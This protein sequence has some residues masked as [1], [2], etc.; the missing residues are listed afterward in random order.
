M[1]VSL[2]ME[3]PTEHLLQLAKV[4]HD[5]RDKT[6]LVCILVSAFVATVYY[7]SNPRVQ[8]PLP[9]IIDEFLFEPPAHN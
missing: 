9:H 5:L 7:H 6:V 1:L 4:I 3:Q 2:L 8:P